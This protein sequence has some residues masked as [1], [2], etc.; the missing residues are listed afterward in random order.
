VCATDGG[1]NPRRPIICSGVR[2][3]DDDDDGDDCAG[4]PAT[5]DE[6]IIMVVIVLNLLPPQRHGRRAVVVVVVLR[7]AIAEENAWRLTI[8][9]ERANGARHTTTNK[10]DDNSKEDMVYGILLNRREDCDNQTI[11]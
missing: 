9:K 5:D 4:E 7:T 1:Y 3:D 11:Q 10:I 2:D 8:A 6:A